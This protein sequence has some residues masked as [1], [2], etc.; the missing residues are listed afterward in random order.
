MDVKDAV[1]LAKAYV[2]EVFAEED[3]LDVGL[4]ETHFDEAAARWTITIG[5][6]RPFERKRTKSKDSPSIYG[7]PWPHESYENRWYKSVVID[8]EAGQVL[9]MRDLVLRSAA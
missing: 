7:M 8:S 9:S 6:R 3:I 1:R 2:R 4:E 5:F